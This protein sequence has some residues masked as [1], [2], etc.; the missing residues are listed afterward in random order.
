[1]QY[2][3]LL[4]NILLLCVYTTQDDTNIVAMRYNLFLNALSGYIRVGSSQ[5]ILVFTF[6]TES[7]VTLLYDYLYL[8]APSSTQIKHGNNNINVS[9]GILKGILYEDSIFIEDNNFN[10]TI[11]EA[12][13]FYYNIIPSSQQVIE[14]DDAS[15][16]AF[17]FNVD[18]PNYSLAHLYV[19]NNITTTKQFGI[20]RNITAV[21][22]RAHAKDG[23]LY[24]GGFPPHIT[25]SLYDNVVYINGNSHLWSVSLDYIYIGSNYKH[26]YSTKE[27]VAYL[28]TSKEDIVVP[29]DVYDKVVLRRYF[30]KENRHVKEHCVVEKYS[31]SVSCRCDKVNLFNSMSFI[32]NDKEYLIES[33]YLFKQNSDT[34]CSFI[35][36]RNHKMK[37]KRIVLGIYFIWQYQT[38]FDYDNKC[39]H[40]YSENRL[41]TVIINEDYERYLQKRMIYI[42]IALLVMAVVFLVTLLHTAM[43]H[44]SQLNK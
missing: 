24:I 31:D 15:T 9:N 35:I 22:S 14:I 5:N 41:N 25:Q 4:L 8:G 23:V 20:A 17:A 16:L 18:N 39:V 26:A 19:H 1:M 32:I 33:K 7:P 37:A 3:L 34:Y 21:Y 12:K 27:Y 43:Y 10:A 38:L 44:Q 36:S 13:G 6:D 2:A 42:N 30:G 29:S 11:A 40:L 28:S